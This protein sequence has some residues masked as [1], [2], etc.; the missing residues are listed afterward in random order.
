MTPVEPVGGRDGRVVPV[1]AVTGGRTRS[2]GRDLPVE[3][4]VTATDQ[5][6]DDLQK[7]Y[8][9]ILD[10]AV[11]PVSL[12]EIGAALRVP[13]GVARVLVGDLADAGYLVVHAPAPRDAAGNPTPAVL[14][15]LLA[16]LRAR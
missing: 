13:V 5:R 9:M 11:A 6:P 2:T 14:T 16:G 8:R 15:R 1:F 7:E 3:S 4:L 10:A 12:V